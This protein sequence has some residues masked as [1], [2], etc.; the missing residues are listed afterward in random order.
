LG[1]MEKQLRKHRDKAKEVR[2]KQDS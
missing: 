2:L 1:K